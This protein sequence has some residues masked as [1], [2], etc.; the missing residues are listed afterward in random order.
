VQKELTTYHS[1]VVKFVSGVKA[2]LQAWEE[3]AEVFGDESAEARERRT[4]RMAS[5]GGMSVAAAAEAGGGSR[6]GGGDSVD[7]N[8][9]WC[10]T[11]TFHNTHAS[12]MVKCEVCSTT[13]PPTNA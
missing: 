5:G 1:A 11:C 12:H 13:R 2:Q 7:D 9:W 8:A 6:G 10:V 3:A 4:Q